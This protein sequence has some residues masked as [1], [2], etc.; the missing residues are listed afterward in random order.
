M[1]LKNH[2]MFLEIN[3][4]TSYLFCEEIKE[5]CD[6]LVKKLDD[7]DYSSDVKVVNCFKTLI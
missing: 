1:H 5:E 4:T 7:K 6:Y 3:T 2:R